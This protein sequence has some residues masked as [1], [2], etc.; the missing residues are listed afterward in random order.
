M[1]EFEVAAEE[2]PTALDTLTSFYTSN[3]SSIDN[4]VNTAQSAW[5]QL[6]SAYQKNAAANKQEKAV[7]GSGERKGRRSKTQAH[8]ERIFLLKKGPEFLRPVESGITKRNVRATSAKH[9]YQSKKRKTAASFV[10]QLR[11]MA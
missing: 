1:A 2:G 6:K 7:E 11:S 9:A 5:S 3:K 10:R 4:A 8:T